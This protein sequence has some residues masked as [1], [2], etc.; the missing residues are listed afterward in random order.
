METAH[1]IWTIKLTSMPLYEKKIDM[2]RVNIIRISGLAMS[3]LL[4][5]MVWQ[6]ASGRSRALKLAERMTSELQ[7]SRK[8]LIEAQP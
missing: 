2:S 1:H 7:Q 8:Q 3:M 5:L 6:L 4:A